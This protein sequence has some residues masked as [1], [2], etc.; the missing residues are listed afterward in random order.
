[1]SSRSVNYDEGVNDDPYITWR[2]SGNI[3]YVQ[4][5]FKVVTEA[6]YDLILGNYNDMVSAHYFFYGDEEESHY[7][8]WSK[9][10]GQE[11]I[12][13]EIVINHRN[14]YVSQEDVER[15]RNMCTTVKTI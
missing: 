11:G 1:M 2:N 5:A 13:P 9:I 12:L 15:L 4:L 14:G 8:I 10:L 6:M 7:K 3:G